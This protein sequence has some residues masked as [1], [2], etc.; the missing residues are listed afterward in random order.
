[1]ACK[2]GSP[3][4]VDGAVFAV[5]AAIKYLEE[6][7]VHAAVPLFPSDFRRLFAYA[8]GPDVAHHRIIHYLYGFVAIPELDELLGDHLELD[9]VRLGNA[10]TLRSEQRERE[11]DEPEPEPATAAADS[12]E[13]AAE[14]ADHCARGEKILGDTPP[15]RPGA[16]PG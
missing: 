15:S 4:Q 6:I 13:P 1:M 16:R 3:D 7:P 14:A 8:V 11:R 10:R 5:F 2:Y 9:V 12:A